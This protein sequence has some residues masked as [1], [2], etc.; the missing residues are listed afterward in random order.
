MNAMMKAVVAARRVGNMS[1]PNQPMYRRLSV[2]VIQLEKRS[3]VGASSEFLLST[4]KGLREAAS[5]LT[6][7]DLVSISLA[8]TKFKDEVVVR[9]PAR[10]KVEAARG[11]VKASEVEA[12]SATTREKESFILKEFN[13]GSD[14]LE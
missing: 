7:S 4:S 11:A 13:R 8:G 6:R 1:V 3:Q 12:R 5:S 10:L 9:A 2:L 14:S